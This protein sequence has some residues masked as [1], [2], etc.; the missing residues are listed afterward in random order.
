ME[1]LYV[2]DRALRGFQQI[3]KSNGITL[4][5]DS[6]IGI[7]QYGQVKVWLNGN[8]ALNACDPQPV[9]YKMLD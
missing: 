6:M 7:N 4:V 8:F 9:S 3:F 1:A 2:M 5:K